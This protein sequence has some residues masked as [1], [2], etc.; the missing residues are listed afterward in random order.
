MNTQMTAPDL[1]ALP[2]NLLH[3]SWLYD[4]ITAD[5][6]GFCAEDVE[7]TAHVVAGWI[8]KHYGLTALQY[9]ALVQAAL[10]EFEGDVT[11]LLAVSAPAGEF[12]KWTK[13]EDYSDYAISRVLGHESWDTAILAGISA[14][15]ARM[16]SGQ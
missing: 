10:I 13:Q 5:E 1:I 16:S 11:F 15:E 6:I 9:E 8:T 14:Y 12:A 2:A 4:G 7:E 3:E